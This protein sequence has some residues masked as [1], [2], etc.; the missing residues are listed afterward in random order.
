MCPSG[1][2]TA[3]HIHTACQTRE[4]TKLNRHNSL[5]LCW[6]Y[7]EKKWVVVAILGWFARYCL[8]GATPPKPGHLRQ[9]PNVTTSYGTPGGA[10]GTDNW[11]SLWLS[12]HSFSQYSPTGFTRFDVQ[13]GTFTT[14]RPMC[15]VSEHTMVY[16][17]GE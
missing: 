8:A 17:E 4:Q 12:R 13:G 15:Y 6:Y 16:V 5:C 7:Y 11:V 14:A 1:P 9:P 2:N 3:P 10:E